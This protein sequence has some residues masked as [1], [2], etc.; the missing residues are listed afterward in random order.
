MSSPF[1]FGTCVPSHIPSKAPLFRRETAQMSNQSN[2]SVLQL[3]TQ[4]SC[5]GHDTISTASGPAGIM[6]GSR[7]DTLKDEGQCR[8]I[9]MVR[10]GRASAEPMSCQ[11]DRSPEERGMMTTDV[12][13]HLL[14]TGPLL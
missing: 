13:E 3:S 8:S 5:G 14:W 10:P 7:A 1:T 4:N 11:R 9:M 12:A 2:H 6:P